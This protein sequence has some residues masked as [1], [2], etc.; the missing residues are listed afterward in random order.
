MYLGT[1]IYSVARCFYKNVDFNNIN[2]YNIK[3][4][5]VN[6]INILSLD[7]VYETFKSVVHNLFYSMISLEVFKIFSSPLIN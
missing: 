5:V 2:I 6:C 3:L 7:N 1:Y 4:K